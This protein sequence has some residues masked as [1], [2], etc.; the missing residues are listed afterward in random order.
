[1]DDS[2]IIMSGRDDVKGGKKNKNSKNTKN[3]KTKKEKTVDVNAHRIRTATKLFAHLKF[4]QT[5]FRDAEAKAAEF[6]VRFQVEKDLAEELRKKG[7]PE[8]RLSEPAWSLGDQ[9]PMVR[10]MY[11]VLDRHVLVKAMSVG[12]ASGAAVPVSDDDMQDS[13]ERRFAFAF[14]C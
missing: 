2:E 3:K 14:G 6:F 10:L 4:L 13:N 8:E 1:M 5:S 7:V 12:C 11:T 9:A